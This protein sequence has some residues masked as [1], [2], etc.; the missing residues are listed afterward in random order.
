MSIQFGR[1]TSRIGRAEWRPLAR[2]G[3]RGFTILE[4]LVVV[5]IIGV[6]AALLLPAVQA[7]RE[8]ARDLE[9]GNRL[10]QLGV[11]LHTYHDVHRKLPA[12]WKCEAT[13]RTSY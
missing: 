12:G 5:A 3:L 11:A 1:T 7:A 9:C 8:A 10:R 2:V 13:A 4:L 6:L